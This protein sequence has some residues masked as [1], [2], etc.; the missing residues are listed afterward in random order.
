MWMCLE[1]STLSGGTP[2]SSPCPSTFKGNEIGHPPLLNSPSELHSGD[3]ERLLSFPVRLLHQHDALS[4]TIENARFKSMDG[5]IKVSMQSRKPFSMMKSTIVSLPLHC[6]ICTFTSR[7]TPHAETTS[8]LSTLGQIPCLLYVKKTS[9]LAHAFARTHLL[10]WA[11]FVLVRPMRLL[12]VFPHLW[13]CSSCGSCWSNPMLLFF[14]F[15]EGAQWQILKIS[16][17]EGQSCHLM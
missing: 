5:T 14:F 15:Y 11:S 17:R 8:E 10:L 13:S 6:P 7:A 1:A 4:S 12:I 16:L 2:R 9:F 3:W